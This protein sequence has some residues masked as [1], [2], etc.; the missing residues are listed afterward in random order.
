MAFNNLKTFL[1]KRKSKNPKSSGE[2]IGEPYD[3]QR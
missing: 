1:T 2:S 3:F